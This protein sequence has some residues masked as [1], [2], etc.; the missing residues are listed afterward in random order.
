LPGSWKPVGCEHRAQKCERQRKQR[1][2]DL[3]HF[4]R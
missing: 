4:Q 3:D 2:L 1:V